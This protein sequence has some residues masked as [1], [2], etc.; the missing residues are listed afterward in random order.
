MTPTPPGAC[1]RKFNPHRRT[2][3]APAW[4]DHV[5]DAAADRACYSSNQQPQIAMPF[6]PHMHVHI[7][8]PA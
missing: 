8:P 2:D 3:A 1:E 4:V 6:S 7:Q 5:S